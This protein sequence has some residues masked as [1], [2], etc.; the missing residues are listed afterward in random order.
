MNF[1]GLSYLSG[2]KKVNTTTTDTSSD[3][4]VMSGQQQHQN[5]TP[6]HPQRDANSPAG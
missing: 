1:N 2:V 6:Q 5:P 3:S 4:V